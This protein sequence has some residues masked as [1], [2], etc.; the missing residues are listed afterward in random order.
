MEEIIHIYHSNDLHSHLEHWPAINKLLTERRRWH[1]ETG[2]EVLIFDIGDHMDRWHPLSDGTRGKAN[3]TLLNEAGYDAATI[4]NNEGIT[5]PFE[6]LDSMYLEKKFELLVA[7]LFK[8]DGSRPTWAKPYY[9]YISKKGTKIG[10]IGMTVNFARFYEQLGWKL[11][12]P[13][14]E[15][16]KCVAELKGKADVIILLSH[17]G[18]HDDELIAGQFPEID[19]ILGG[20]THHILHEGKEVGSTLLAGAGKYGYYTGHVMLKL[21]CDTKGILSKKACLYDMKELP[22]S[23]IVD[24]YYSIGKQLMNETVATLP[25]E[26][27]AEPLAHSALVKMLTQALREWCDA[28][29]AFMNAGMLLHGLKSGPVTQ[30]DLL[31]ICPHPINPCTIKL[32]GAEL[33]EVLL[34]TRDEKWPHMQIKGLGF[35]GSVMGVMEYDGIEFIIRNNVHQILINGDPIQAKKMYELAI[36]DMFTFGRFFP[37]IY[38]AAE[39]HYW[40]P[41]FLRNLLEWKLV[42]LYK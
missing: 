31:E 9:V 40:L 38:R 20:H 30:F 33:K 14:E 2:E 1:E 13:I 6:D 27:P 26:L 11:T 41:E 8:Q 23:E 42:N 5:L 35:R 29:C 39:K 32:S 3:C 25:A 24:D 18:I 21:D 22:Q 15:L 19:V 4:G 34:Q 12:D 37:E 16:A 10:V 28:D 7:N 36:P 17:L